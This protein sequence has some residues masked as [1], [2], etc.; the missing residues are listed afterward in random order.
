MDLINSK[1][2]KPFFLWGDWLWGDDPFSN[3]SGDSGVLAES[4]HL[5][6]CGQ[7]EVR[8]RGS[9]QSFPARKIELSLCRE[10]DDTK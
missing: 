10:G 1:Q 8:Q 4:Q 3:A 7:V 5:N 2:G 9:D 6:S